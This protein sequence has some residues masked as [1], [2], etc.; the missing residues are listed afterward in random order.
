MQQNDICPL[1]V[2]LPYVLF[3]LQI[4]T[5]TSTSYFLKGYGITDYL[6]YAQKSYT[7]QFKTTESVSLPLVAKYILIVFKILLLIL[8]YYIYFYT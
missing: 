5:F 1:H 7:K 4:V 3:S 8:W 6:I 2:Y